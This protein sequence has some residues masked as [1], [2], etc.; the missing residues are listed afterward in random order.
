MAASDKK[1]QLSMLENQAVCLNNYGFATNQKIQMFFDSLAKPDVNTKALAESICYR[2]DWMLNEEL[3]WEARYET[4]QKDREDYLKGQKETE[5]VQK[6]LEGEFPKLR[7]DLENASA[8]ASRHL[9]YTDMLET[10]NSIPSRAT[11]EN[12]MQVEKETLKSFEQERVELDHEFSQRKQQCY[13]LFTNIQELEEKVQKPAPKKQDEVFDRK[14][15]EEMDAEVLKKRLLEAI[16]NDAAL[17]HLPAKL[18]QGTSEGFQAGLESAGL[19]D[20]LNA[21]QEG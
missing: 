19:T 6:T 5:D 14:P 13:A 8:E 4:C 18:L 1:S 12:N 3:L 21:L 2:L 15:L 11:S 10:I 9:Q 7:K 16:K 20:M 17:E